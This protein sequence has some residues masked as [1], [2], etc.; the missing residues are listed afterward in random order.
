[1]KK[2][3]IDRSFVND[4]AHDPDDAVIVKS[5]VDLAHN[6]ELKVVA[7]GVETDDQLKMLKA[8]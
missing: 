2:L 5:I 6:L 8:M 4:I 3:K 7:E 1:M